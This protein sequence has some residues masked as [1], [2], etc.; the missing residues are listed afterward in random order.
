LK[1]TRIKKAIAKRVRGDKVESKQHTGLK[2]RDVFENVEV[3]IMPHKNN[4]MLSESI[5]SRD[6]EFSF[7]SILDF[8]CCNRRDGSLFQKL[9]STKDTMDRLA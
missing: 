8:L 4:T 3:D 1:E 7:L 5:V 6:Y 2:R 9:L